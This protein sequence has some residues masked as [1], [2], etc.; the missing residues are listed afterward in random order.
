VSATFRIAV[1]G[2]TDARDTV[3]RRTLTADVNAIA[4][5]IVAV[6][7][8]VVATVIV[9]VIA[10]ASV[11]PTVSVALLSFLQALLLLLPLFIAVVGDA[12]VQ[13]GE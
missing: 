8:I 2:I 7:R 3:V 5:L 11:V 12:A 10:V 13:N 1:L 6:V 9:I 4:E